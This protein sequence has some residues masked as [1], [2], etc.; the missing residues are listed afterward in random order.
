MVSIDFFL[1][2]FFVEKK[3]LYLYYLAAFFSLC[4]AVNYGLF[5]TRPWVQFCCKM[6]GG[7]AW[8]E[9][10]ILRNLKRK[11][12]GPWHIISVSLIA[13]PVSPT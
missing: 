1:V 8:C 11:M 2:A 5:Y 7:T 9:N 3:K 6:W 13:S 4:F 10:N 12:W